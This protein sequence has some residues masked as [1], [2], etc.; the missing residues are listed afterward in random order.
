MSWSDQHW[1][2]LRERKSN[3]LTR[4]D[5]IFVDDSGACSSAGT[6][7]RASLAARLG[8]LL[9]SLSSA[10]FGQKYK[11]ESDMA[12]IAWC[13][14]SLIFVDRRKTWVRLTLRVKS[15]ED[16]HKLPGVT[17]TRIQDWTRGYGVE[18]VHHPMRRRSLRARPHLGLVFDNARRDQRARCWRLPDE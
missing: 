5:R 4:Q 8:G 1:V 3:L 18:R 16:A 12:R 7:H 2:S 13:V 10:Y 9:R 11:M 6:G 17:L 15:I 14:I